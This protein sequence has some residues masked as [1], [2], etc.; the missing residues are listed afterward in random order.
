VA[1][2]ELAKV[3]LV[4]HDLPAVT[5]ELGAFASD[6][7]A[8]ALDRRALAMLDVLDTSVVVV[9]R[10]RERGNG[11]CRESCTDCE[12]LLEREHDRFS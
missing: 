6:L 1:V 5:S 2:R 10:G 9:V 8:K 11:E 3:A 12:N 7:I 4:S